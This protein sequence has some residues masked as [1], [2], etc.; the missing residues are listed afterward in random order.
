MAEKFCPA[1]KYKNQADATVCAYCGA[2]L[3]FGQVSRTTTK[4]V[5]GTTATSLPPITKDALLKTQAPRQGIAFYIQDRVEPIETRDDRQFMLGRKVTEDMGDAFVDL[6]PYGGFE[7]GV[8]RRH[9]MIHQTKNGY[10]ITDLAST[11]G[12]FLNNQRLIPNEPYPLHNGAQLQLGRMRLLVL[13]EM[14]PQKK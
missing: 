10:E 14:A 11:N 4:H 8:S 9:A 7:N 1:C 2:P 6:D 3:E 12:T 5:P 13:Y